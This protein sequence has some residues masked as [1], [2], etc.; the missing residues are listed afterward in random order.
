MMR[1]LQE[2]DQ[3]KLKPP[4]VG[5]TFPFDQLPEA[6]RLFRTGKTQGKVVVR[7]EE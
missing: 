5:H 6:V 2:L 7:L 3:L 1:L 4:H